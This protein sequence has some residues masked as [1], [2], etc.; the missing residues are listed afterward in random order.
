MCENHHCE[1]GEKSKQLQRR[2]GEVVVSSFV[3]V[4]ARRGGRCAW[5]RGLGEVGKRCLETVTANDLG[6][7]LWKLLG[8]GKP[9][10]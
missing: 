10:E 5:I 2:R 8:V 1:T 7:M 9:T 3:H 6:V 4:C